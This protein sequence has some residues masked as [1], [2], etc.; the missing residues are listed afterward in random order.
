M[1][2]LF[3]KI[4]Y[5][6]TVKEIN[7]YADSIEDKTDIDCKVRDW[8]DTFKCMYS[9]SAFDKPYYTTDFPYVVE[10]TIS[11]ENGHVTAHAYDYE[12]YC[13]WQKECA[14]VFNAWEQNP[15]SDIPMPD[16]AER[17][18]FEF[19]VTRGF[20]DVPDRCDVDISSDLDIVCAIDEYIDE[21]EGKQKVYPWMLKQVVSAADLGITEEE[22]DYLLEETLA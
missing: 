20:S 9:S 5:K 8:I 19:P 11:E 12:E 14:S 1:E 3:Y 16:I 15:D 7:E 21:R 18:S 4:Q 17:F 10:L 13:K 6:L 22:Y 2:N